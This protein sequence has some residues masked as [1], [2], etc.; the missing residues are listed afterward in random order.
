MENFIY[1]LMYG[2]DNKKMCINDKVRELENRINKLVHVKASTKVIDLDSRRI[3]MEITID[4]INIGFSR[5]IMFS[6][7]KDIDKIYND[8]KKQ[9]SRIVLIYFNL[10]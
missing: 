2:K 1:N 10:K 8:I 4:K 7:L 3:D 9:I 6:D 5:F